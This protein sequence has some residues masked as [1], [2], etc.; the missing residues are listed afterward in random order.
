MFSDL[1]VF[2]VQVQRETYLI[3]PDQ[4]TPSQLYKL[5]SNQSGVTFDIEIQDMATSQERKIIF[6]AHYSPLLESPTIT[7]MS[8]TSSLICRGNYGNIYR[9]ML[10]HNSIV[11]NHYENNYQLI[12]IKHQIIKFNEVLRP[13]C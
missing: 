8:K 9:T 10:L 4:C 2:D 13:D 6:V 5:N 12:H 3:S 11:S 7:E 1:I